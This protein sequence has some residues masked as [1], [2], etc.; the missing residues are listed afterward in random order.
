[1]GNKSAKDTYLDSVMTF[2]M[3]LEETMRLCC[4]KVNLPFVLSPD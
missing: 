1:M 4:L 3:M 2:I